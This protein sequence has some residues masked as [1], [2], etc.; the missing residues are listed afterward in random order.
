MTIY[1]LV[2]WIW[3]VVVALFITAVYFQLLPRLRNHV[4]V[5]L[6]RW[7]FALGTKSWHN[8]VSLDHGHFNV[9][10]K[11]VHIII[12]PTRTWRPHRPNVYLAEWR[13]IRIDNSRWR[14]TSLGVHAW[15]VG[16]ALYWNATCYDCVLD[17]SSDLSAYD[18]EKYEQ[19]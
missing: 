12:A 15:P 14:S 10:C 11:H 16:F 3:W 8:Y 17:Y 1:W 13:K 18:E 6:Y 2:Y 19:L 4:A 7:G 9:Y 5:S